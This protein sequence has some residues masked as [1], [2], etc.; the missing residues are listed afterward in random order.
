MLFKLS[1][2]R[3]PGLLFPNLMCL[4]FFKK[5][6]VCCII[7]VTVI[8]K[9][10]L[11]YFRMNLQ[12]LNLWVKMPSSL[13]SGMRLFV[14]T[15]RTLVTLLEQLAWHPLLSTSYRPRRA[16]LRIPRSCCRRRIWTGWPRRV[17]T[18]FITRPSAW[19][20]WGDCSVSLL[21]CVL[22]NHRDQ[23]SGSYCLPD[24]Q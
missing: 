6:C 14:P 13:V 12:K 19:R 4:K 10:C 17:I 16:S 24:A 22:I 5:M 15:L 18:L 20:S 2:T 1:S 9:A 7:F 8:A 23:V 3:G 11:F 21:V